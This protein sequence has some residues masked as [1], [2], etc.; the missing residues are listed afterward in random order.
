M[1]GWLYPKQLVGLGLPHN[2]VLSYSLLLILASALGFLALRLV[3]RRI[4]QIGVARRSYT[5]ACVVGAAGLALLALAPS[6]LIGGIG[7]LLARGIADSVTRPISVIWV[8]RRTTSDVRA[9]VHSFLSQAESVGEIIG[10][11]VLAGIAL[12]SGLGT[13][14]LTAGG[15]LALTGIMVGLSRADRTQVKRHSGQPSG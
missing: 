15:L 6:A 1:V 8:N 4:D 11:F 12:A 5:I 2:P 7:V 10:G 13:T 14:F 9:T 3:G